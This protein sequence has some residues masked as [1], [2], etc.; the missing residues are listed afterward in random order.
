MDELVLRNAQ[1]GLTF[2]KVEWNGEDTV[3]GGDMRDALRWDTTSHMV[4]TLKEGK[5]YF[6]ID[7]SA[8]KSKYLNFGEF[9]NAKIEEVRR[10]HRPS[11]MVYLIT[12]QGAMKLIATRRP[13]EI[14]DDPE[15]S[16]YL[17]KLQDWI[18][19]EVLPAVFEHGAYM[20]PQVAQNVLDD[21][22]TAVVLAKEVLKEH[23]KRLQAESERDEAIRR[24]GEIS[25]TREAKI[26][27][28]YGQLVKKQRNLERETETKSKECQELTEKNRRLLL[29]LQNAIRAYQNKE[30][31]LQDKCSHKKNK[32]ED[33]RDLL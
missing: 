16:A 7:V 29:E 33:R 21:P 2:H 5:E 31:E 30:A 20:T 28:M 4:Y 24:K 32:K 9:I 23:S 15:L 6:K 8:C 11:K 26:L 27:G 1:L 12:R 14:K 17:D 3:W 13:H 22:N 10:S 25:N 19:G 18:F